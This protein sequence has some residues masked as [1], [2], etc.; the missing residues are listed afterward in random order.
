MGVRSGSPPR[1]EGGPEAGRSTHDDDHHPARAGCA[2]DP[3]TERRRHRTP[4]ANP[5]GAP[6]PPDRS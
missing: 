3:G 6:V 4:A 2:R 1:D 5:D